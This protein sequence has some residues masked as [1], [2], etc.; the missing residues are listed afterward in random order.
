MVILYVFLVVQLK[1]PLQMVNN[2]W[3]FEK[4]LK[5]QNSKANDIKTLH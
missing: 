3:V 1:Y 4:H 5:E 2:I